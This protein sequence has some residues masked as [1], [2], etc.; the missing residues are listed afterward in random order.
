MSITLSEWVLIALHVLTKDPQ[1]I[2]DFQYLFPNITQVYGGTTCLQAPNFGSMGLA[3]GSPLTFM[4]TFQVGQRR[5]V[6]LLLRLHIQRGP[7]CS[8]PSPSVLFVRHWQTGPSRVST[9]QCADV[10]L[11]ETNTW[12]AA[13]EYECKN[14]TRSTQTRGNGNTAAVSAD[15]PAASG[16]SGSSSSGSG[17]ST[18]T[19][20]ST[21]ESGISKAAAG[22]I[23]AGVTLAIMAAIVAVLAFTGFVSFG[24]KNT[25]KAPTATEAGRNDGYHAD[26]AVSL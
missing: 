7:N 3:A 4:V 1:S 18:G 20:N 2:D 21:S 13:S 23:G 8:F 11:V 22:G 25:R 24:K 14:F 5:P 26:A 16:N 17:P 15:A 19:L 12:V 10:N 6:V 9:F